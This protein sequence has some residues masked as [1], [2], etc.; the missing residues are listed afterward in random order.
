MTPTLPTII[1]AAATGP[2]TTAAHQAT[3]V[4]TRRRGAAKRGSRPEHGETR[5]R[6]VTGKKGRAFDAA[7]EE[8]GA[9]GEDH[10]GDAQ[11]VLH[12]RHGLRRVVGGH[13]PLHRLHPSSATAAAARRTLCPIESE[14]ARGA[15]LAPPRQATNGTRAPPPP[16]ESR[17]EQRFPQYLR[18]PQKLERTESTRDHDRE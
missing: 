2:T 5:T 4:R 17:K 18:A 15:S 13:P 9:E 3:E 1:T 6:S 14:A 16:P 11:R 7:E 10:V 12:R 8:G